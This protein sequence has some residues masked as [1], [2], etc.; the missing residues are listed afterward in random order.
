MLFNTEV[1]GVMMIDFE[2]ALLLEPP[3]SPF[4][5]L[6]LNKR[7]WKPDT[8]ESIKSTGKSCDRGQASRVFCDEIGQM[9]TVF[10]VHKQ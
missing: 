2:R 7:K 1:N 10:A 8:A 4:G 5:Q 6:V 3:R 9:K